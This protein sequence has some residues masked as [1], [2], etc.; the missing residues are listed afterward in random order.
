MGLPTNDWRNN[1]WICVRLPYDW[2]WYI[3]EIFS[4]TIFTWAFVS[5]LE[6]NK[7]PCGGSK[8]HYLNVNTDKN[9]TTPTTTWADV[10][11]W[12]AAPQRD[13]WAPVTAQQLRR[14]QEEQGPT[15]DCQYGVGSMS[16]ESRHQR[17]KIWD[18]FIFVA[19]WH[20]AMLAFWQS[21]STAF[22]SSWGWIHTFFMNLL[23]QRITEFIKHILG[24]AF[25][26]PKLRTVEKPSFKKAPDWITSTQS[27]ELFY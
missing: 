24:A 7:R 22:G 21:L 9:C 27:N 13:P 3:G 1:P 19:R 18:R 6:D 17:G 11:Q 10:I 12:I 25:L 8:R 4:P 14:F 15:F 26:S 5:F 2:L 16:S 23:L 20:K